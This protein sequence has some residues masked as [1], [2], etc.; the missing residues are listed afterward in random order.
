M[1][2]GGKRQEVRVGNRAL[3]LSNLDKVLWPEVGFTK[4][5]MVGYYARIAE[6]MIPHLAGRP[7]TLK[8]Y[9]EGVDGPSFF[10]KNCPS[11]KPDWVRTVT[12]GDVAYCLVDEPAALVWLANLAAIELHPTLARMPELSRPSAVVFD[13]DP[14]PPADILT[15]V[16]VSRLLREALD[17]LRLRCLV[18]TSGSKGLQ[19][20]VPL[21]GEAG[22]DRT[23]AFAHALAQLL[24][25][26][27]PDLVVSTQDK[28]RR[29]GKVLIDWSQ[30][31]ESKTTVSVYSL[32]ARRR[33]SVSTP[34]SWE[35][36]DAALEAGDADTL[37]FGPEEVLSRLEAHGDL[38]GSALTGG[39]A[40]PDSIARAV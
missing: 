33:P 34:L 7:L 31:T 16:R 23:K 13:L 19:L 22:Y 36:V 6:V 25:R 18:K 28:A 20:Y 8:R 9:P 4:G 32:R 15:C 3:S 29:A 24:E 10:E 40:L 39:Q 2:S 5:E 17:H 26:A 38:M 1:S 21:D 27:H 30:N 14:G 12:M 11:H 35:E 37:S